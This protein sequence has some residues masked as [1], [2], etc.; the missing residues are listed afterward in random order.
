MSKS[1]ARIT[2]VQEKHELSDLNHRLG[3][4]ALNVRKVTEN[5]GLLR[6][7][8]DDLES[9][10]TEELRS[11]KEVYMTEI[12]ELRRLLEEEVQA[13]SRLEVLHRKY[14]EELTHLRLQVRVLMGVVLCRIFVYPIPGLCVSGGGGGGAA[15]CTYVRGVHSMT[16]LPH[17]TPP[18]PPPPAFLARSAAAPV[19]PAVPTHTPPPSLCSWISFAGLRYALPPHSL[20]HT[21]THTLPL[22]NHSSRSPLLTQLKDQKAITAENRLL[23]KDMEKMEHDI[24]EAKAA[25]VRSLA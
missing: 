5:E 22:H 14:E 3:L 10:K 7:Q 23:H 17:P 9:E 12:E 6:Q 25:A 15:A 18:S 11:Q 4:Y 19:L 1:P 8:I 13:R 21:H 2:R 20:T 16:P 24:E